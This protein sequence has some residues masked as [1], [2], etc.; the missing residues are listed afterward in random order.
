MIVQK[1]GQEIG[2]RLGRSDVLVDLE[3]MAKHFK[4]FAK[5]KWPNYCCYV[6]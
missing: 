4:R 1:R 6:K 3:K 5:K 2:R